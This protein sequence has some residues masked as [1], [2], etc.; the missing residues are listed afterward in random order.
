MLSK[1]VLRGAVA[2]AGVAVLAGAGVAYADT[3]GGSP[4][5]SSG[6]TTSAALAAASSSGGAT[7]TRPD[8]AHRPGT[9]LLHRLEHG[10]FTMRGA[11]GDVTVD[12]QRGMVSTVSATSI[13]VTSHDGFRATYAIG[14]ATRVRHDRA[15]VTIASVHTGDQ[16]LVVGSGGTAM[17]IRD[18]SGS[19]VGG[20][21]SGG[22]SSGA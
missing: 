14:A 12:V 3:S 4:A 19:A 5:S 18:R 6:A 20:S 7:T 9:A 8:K 17:G 21:S 11:T 10:Q 2:A 13:T 15:P 1:K 16:V 22:S